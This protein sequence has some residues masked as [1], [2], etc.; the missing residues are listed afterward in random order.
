MSFTASQARLFVVGVFVDST[1]VRCHGKVR[2]CCYGSERR[3]QDY[4]RYD[5]TDLQ[6]GHSPDVEKE[7]NK[8]K[9]VEEKEA[10]IPEK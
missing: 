2:H 9:D 8:G 10:P 3:A 6:A 5:L 4:Q 7:T 1:T